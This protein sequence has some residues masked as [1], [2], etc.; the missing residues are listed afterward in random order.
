MPMV[1]SRSAGTEPKAKVS[2]RR[3]SAAAKSGPGPSSSRNAHG[4]ASSAPTTMTASWA[5]SVYTTATI[6]P[7]AV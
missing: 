4:A 6:P 5:R 2:G 1:N 7:T 3:A